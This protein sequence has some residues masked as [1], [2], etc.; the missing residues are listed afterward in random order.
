M[1][2]EEALRELERFRADFY[3]EHLSPILSEAIEKAKQAIRD[4][5]EMGLT[6]DYID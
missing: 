3:E 1:T 5:L 6:G 2:Y 4:C